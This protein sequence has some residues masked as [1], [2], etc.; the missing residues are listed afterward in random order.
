MKYRYFPTIFLLLFISACSGNNQGPVATTL[1]NE[2]A[3]STIEIPA[4]EISNE[5]IALVNGEAI[6]ESS[7]KF[8]LNLYEA[9]LIENGTFL[10]IE[11]IERVV[12]E[13]LIART[14]LAQAARAAGFAATEEILAERLQSSIDAA[15]GEAA[16]EAWLAEFGLKASDFELELALEIEAAWMRNELAIAVPTHTEQIE[17]RQIL[18]TELFQAERLLGQL[19]GG[20]PFETVA[21]NNDPQGLG[22]L[23]WF[24]RGY[25]LQSE[26]EEAAFALQPGE[27]SLVVES[28]IGFHLIEILNRDANRELSP[29]ARLELQRQA[30][31]EWIAEQRQQSDVQVLL[32]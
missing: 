25:L 27:Y 26:V 2:I 15:G 18:L 31:I 5:P 6:S 14:L 3:T 23:G 7:Y 21:I 12:I 30:L 13:D 16:Y 28:E 22:Y 24:P 11:G 10:A 8:S 9:A 4:T 19:E 29:N 20:T 32:P 17:A 1:P